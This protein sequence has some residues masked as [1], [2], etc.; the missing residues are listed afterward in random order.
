MTLY[1]TTTRVSVY[2]YGNYP[3]STGWRMRLISK[4]NNKTLI[5]GEYANIGLTFV[6]E[7]DGWTEFLTDPLDFSI[8]RSNNIGG[9]YEC[10]LEGYTTGW[11]EFDNILCKVKNSY[12]LSDPQVDYLSDNENNEQYVYF[13]K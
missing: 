3:K 8:Q 6:K 5:N 7:G 9:Y 12:D 2:F 11:N 4:Y 1:L 10:I 13:K